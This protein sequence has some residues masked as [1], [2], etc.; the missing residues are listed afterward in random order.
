MDQ[1]SE[2]ALDH[3]F[4]TSPDLLCVLDKNLNF[5]KPTPS[6]HMATGWDLDELCHTSLFDLIH[7]EDHDVLRQK[8]TFL[9]N[10]T[11]P[12]RFECRLVKKDGNLLW[13]DWSIA[14][15]EPYLFATARNI[16]ATKQKETLAQNDIRLLELAEQTARVGHWR[17][18]TAT[19]LLDWST[20]VFNIFGRRPNKSQITLDDFIDAFSGTHQKNMWNQIQQA[21]HNATEIN[22]E[23][24]IKRDDAQRRTV[25]IRAV[26]ETDDTNLVSGIFG[27]IQDVTEERLHQEKMRKKEELLSLAFRATSDGIWDWD[28][29]SDQVWFSPQW[30]AQLGYDDDEISNHFDSW[31]NLIFEEDRLKAMEELDAHF[32]GETD[33]FEMIQRFRHKKGH[34]AFILVRGYAL[35]DEQGAAVRMIGAH[36]DITELKK[37]EQAKSE[38]SAIVSHELRTP[39]TALRGAIGLMNTHYS[40]QIP[41]KLQKLVSLANSNCERLTL[42]VNDIL[43]I[44]KLQSG[45]MDFDIQP[46]TLAPFITEVGESHTLYAKQYDVL[47][48]WETSNE[49][50]CILADCDRLMQVMANLVSN[51]IKFSNKGD[52]VKLRSYIQNEKVALCVIDTG[53]GIPR[54]MRHKI[55]DKFIQAD[56]SDQRHKGGTGLGLTI[57]KAMVE[58]MNGDISVISKEGEGS[59]FTVLLPLVEG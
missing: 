23:L 38:F 47:L 12:V 7:P 37:L 30:K 10:S 44:D 54:D 26:C 36:T 27:I 3:W 51:A 48:D 1:F 15:K 50:L 20:E 11:M 59:T 40:D 45:R 17:L 33:R 35:R 8:L 5:R 22:T 57:A 46:I 6:W 43:D 42:L 16:N 21:M 55:F 39:L 31:A 13:L 9:L 24:V 2:I 28:L 49:S 34:T 25:A 19:G 32:R 52:T 41:D 29:Q 4:E 18:D 56:S 58:K 53:A 14:L